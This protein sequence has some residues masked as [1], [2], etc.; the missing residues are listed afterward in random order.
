[1]LEADSGPVA[2]RRFALDVAEWPRRGILRSEGM[3]RS[4]QEHVD[5]LREALEGAPGE[6]SCPLRRAVLVRA[7][8][9]PDGEMAPVEAAF[10]DA[11]VERPRRS[12]VER[13]LSAGRSEDAVLEITLA[14]ATGAGLA[15][16]RHGL[17]ALRRRR[18]GPTG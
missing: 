12:D 6:T 2:R 16:L 15:R 9:G 11:V 8:G 18:S 4:L 3:Q 17:A 13:L 7:S 1:V 10:A 14:A 5:D